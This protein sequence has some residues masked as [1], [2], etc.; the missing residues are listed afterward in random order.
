[1]PNQPTT[2]SPELAREIAQETYIW[3]YPLVLMDL[4]RRVATNFETNQG[5][6]GQAPINQFSHAKAF[7]P[8]S[9]RDVVRPNF[10]TL[11]SV[12]WL[13]VGPEPLVMT[14]PK[15]NPY[16]RGRGR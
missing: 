10:D 8:T 1:M 9:F 11:Y 16:D 6:L 3:G 13:D 5:I 15:T 14:L 4:T 12:V 2:I 7:P